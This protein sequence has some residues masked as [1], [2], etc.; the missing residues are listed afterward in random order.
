[1]GISDK[2]CRILAINQ[3]SSNKKELHKQLQ[4]HKYLER[5]LPNKNKKT[6]IMKLII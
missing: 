1:V 2:H 6:E 5:T 3:K 4:E